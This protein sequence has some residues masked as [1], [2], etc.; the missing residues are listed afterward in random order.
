MNIFWINGARVEE[1]DVSVL[2]LLGLLRKEKSLMRNMVGLGLER[3]EALE[4]LT[5]SAVAS[6]QKD[7]GVTDGLFDASDRPEGGG[8]VVWWNDFEKDKRC[9]HISACWEFTLNQLC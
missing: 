7:S 4:V 8:V 2:G 9:V 6:A 1:K 3:S 5:H